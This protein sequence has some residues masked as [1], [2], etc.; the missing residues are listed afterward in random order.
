VGLLQIRTHAVVPRVCPALAAN[1]TTFL[2]LPAW[3][4][5][6]VA[7]QVDRAGTPSCCARSLWQVFCC[8][9]AGLLCCILV[10]APS[11]PQCGCG[12]YH[13]CSRVGGCLVL[14]Y[15]SAPRCCVGV[16]LSSVPFACVVGSDRH[17]HT[18]VHILYGTVLVAELVRCWWST[19]CTM[20]A[21]AAVCLLC[22][23]LLDLPR[24]P[25]AAKTHWW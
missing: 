9:V 24:Q 16:G 14:A 6:L 1:R 5:L 11:S 22:V 17:L 2:I 12:A 20:W 19:A 3:L 21:P 23:G 25:A 15:S 7:C 10:E 4:L 13:T 8:L 18:L